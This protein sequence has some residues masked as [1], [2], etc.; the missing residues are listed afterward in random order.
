MNKEEQQ[1]LELVKELVDKADYKEDRTGVGVKGKFCHKLEFDLSDGFPLITTKKMNFKAI[2]AELLWF[3]SGS[4]NERDLCEL[5]HGTRD[6]NKKTIWTD[7]C[8]DASN[9]NPERFNGMNMG[10]MYNVAWRKQPCNPHGIV[11]IRRKTYDDNYVESG[12]GSFFEKTV[13]GV[14]YLGS[15]IRSKNKTTKKL[16][17]VWQDMLIRVYKPRKNHKTYSNVSVCKRWLNFTN[18]VNDCYCLQG[19][20]EFVDSNYSWQLDKDYYGSNIY[21]PN[22]CCFISAEL[23]KKLNG[24]G[25][26]FKVYKYDGLYFFSR[27]DLQNYRGLSRKAS[28]PKNLE[29]IEDSKDYVYRPVI[30]IDQLSRVVDELKNNPT[31]RRLVVDSWNPRQT[32]NAVLGVCHPMYQFVVDDGKLNMVFTV[33]SSDTYLGLGYNVASYAL[34]LTIVAIDA[35]YD[36]GK[37]VYEGHDVHLYLSHIEAALQQ[38]EREPKQKP[39]LIVNKRNSIFE[40]TLEDFKLENYESYSFI[41]APMAV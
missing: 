11:K 2:V 33:R 36:V 13:C 12:K 7:N 14:G 27:T 38:L 37:L 20:Q 5:T 18:F 21:S 32:E 6:E 22:T 28:L 40:Y 3:L 9:K 24:G 8:K 26:G 4:Q 29:I 34:L 23:N 16:Y 30:Y 10:N 17:R 31:S 35:G 39:K 19:F 25:Y 41:Y 1:Y 15:D